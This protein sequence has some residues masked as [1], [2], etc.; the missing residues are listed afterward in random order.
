MMVHSYTSILMAQSSLSPLSWSKN[1]LEHR[2]VA[3]FILLFSFIL[4]I[5]LST[6]ALQL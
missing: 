2:Y 6:M 1:G 4:I 5:W 3:H